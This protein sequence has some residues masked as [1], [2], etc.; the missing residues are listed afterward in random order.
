[1]KDFLFNGDKELRKAWEEAD[2]QGKRELEEPLR[3]LLS[4]ELI[5]SIETCNSANL[6]ILFAEESFKTSSFSHLKAL[7]LSNKISLICFPFLSGH[8]Y[9]F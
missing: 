8:A 5:R 7:K 1:M 3:Q 6:L 2:A 4:I 9:T